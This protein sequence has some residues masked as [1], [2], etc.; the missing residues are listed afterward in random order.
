VDSHLHPLRTVM[1]ERSSSRIRVLQRITDTSRKF[2]FTCTKPIPNVSQKIPPT[3]NAP[4]IIES[5]PE[6]KPL[7]PLLLSHNIPPKLADA[8]ADKYDNHAKRLK[9]TTE[10]QFAP[11]LLNCHSHAAGVYAFFLERY[12]QTLRHWAQTTLNAALKSLKRCS[13][14]FQDLDVTHPNPLW[15]PVRC[16]VLV[17]LGQR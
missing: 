10:L 9:S 8:C 15:L 11:Y 16:P 12:R 2:S 13:A 17:F 3:S 7:L 6:H 4:R 1:T 14:D 5:L